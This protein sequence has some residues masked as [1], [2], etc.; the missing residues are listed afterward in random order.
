VIDNGIGIARDQQK[1]IFRNFYQADQS[2]SREAGGCGLGLSIVKYIVG[3]HGGSVTVASQP[4]EG[5]TFS[6]ALPTVGLP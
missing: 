4:G 5:S 3:A 1:R 2:L 6:I